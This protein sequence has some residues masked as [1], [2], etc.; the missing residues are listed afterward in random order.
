MTMKKFVRI[1]AILCVTVLTFCFAACGDNNDGKKDKY[2]VT[3]NLNYDGAENFDVEVEMDEDGFILVEEPT[4][5]ERANYL[6]KRWCTDAACT[7]PVN[8]EENIEGDVTYYAEWIKTAAVVTFDLNYN[9]SEKNTQTVELNN[10]VSQPA[11][12]KREGY[13]F[14]EWTCDKDGNTAYDFS[15]SVTDDIT[16]YAQWEKLPDG[17]EIVE[18]TINY[19]YDGAPNGGVFD[20]MSIQSGKK[21]SSPKITR[22]GYYLDGWCTDAACTVD[23]DFNKRVQNDITL[24]AKWFKI[25]TFEAEM[26]DYTS[27]K[28]YGYSGDVIGYSAVYKDNF[29]ANA[30]NGYFVTGLYDMGIELTFHVYSDV[31][32]D[33]AYLV[34]RLSAEFQ[35]WTFSDEEFLTTVNGVKVPFGTYS[36]DIS[37]VSDGNKLPFSDYKS[38]SRISLKQGDNVIVLKVNNSNKG[39][40]GTMYAAAPMVDCIK[41]YS[42]NEVTWGEGYPLDTYENKHTG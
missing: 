17:V 23:F 39:L 29:N 15:A 21:I 12:P 14:K 35:N 5:P 11:S 7:S 4:A 34:L 22:E 1:I 25:N 32:V 30:S 9:G 3:F 16:L 19:N 27:F 26:L 13:L 36:F 2:T 18:I 31:A 42:A 40:G 8:F 37:G 28:G 20:V 33:N 38:T 24:Y 10:A 41:I 6:F